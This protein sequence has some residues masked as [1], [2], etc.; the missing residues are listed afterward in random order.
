MIEMSH[1]QYESRKNCHVEGCMEKHYGKGYCVKHYNH[2]KRHGD[3]LVKKT[4]APKYDP[5]CSVVGCS[6]SSSRRGYCS[7]HYSRVRLSG[8]PGP[9]QSY[10]HKKRKSGAWKSWVSI[11]GRCL[12]ENHKAYPSYGGRGIRICERW[13]GVFGFLNFLEDM[14]ERPEGKSNGRAIYSL[15]RIDNDGHYSCGHCEEC[16]ENGW[17]SNCRWATQSIQM[18]NQR[19][20]E[21]K[22]GFRGVRRTPANRYSTR[23]MVDGKR[24]SLGTFSTA[25]EASE[26]YED[27]KKGLIK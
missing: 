12:K 7:M 22:S 6:R 21:N 16:I 14:G 3:P 13:Q 15:D 18:H 2:W 5:I 19:P 20:A 24:K 10:F 25:E 9:V 17:K 23:I 1:S 11:Q 26:V 4:K 8:D 27:F